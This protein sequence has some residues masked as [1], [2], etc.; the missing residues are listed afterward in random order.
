[1]YASDTTEIRRCRALLGGCPGPAGPP[2]VMGPQGNPSPRGNVAIV[3]AV[4]GNDSTASIGGSPYLT[5]SAAVAAVSSGQTVWILPGTY[6]LTTTLTIPSGIAIRGLNLQTCIL[7]MTAS[8]TATMITMGESSR[9]EDLTISLIG[10]LT[11]TGQTLIGIYFGGTSSSTSKLRTSVITVNNSSMSSSLSATVYAIQAAGT[12]TLTPTIFSFN[13]IKGSTINAISNGGGITRGIYLSGTNQMSTRDTNIYV[14]QPK[15]VSSTG[16]YVGV[17]AAESTGVG[18]IQ[19]RTTTIGT[20]LPTTGQSYTASDILQTYPATLTNPTYLASGGIQIGAGTDLITKTAGGQPF[21]TYIY[22]TIIYY[23]LKGTLTSATSGAWLWPGTQAISGGVFPD[24]GTPPAYYRIQQPCLLAGIS[25][26][27][28]T[29][30]SGTYTVNLLVQIIPITSNAIFSGYS[31]G[32]T[33][34]VTSVTSGTIQVGQ[35]LVGIGLNTTTYIMSGSGSTW[36]TNIFQNVANSGAPIV[37]NANGPLINTNFSL[38][39]TGTQISQINYN[40]SYA[41]NVGDRIHLYLTY[42]GAVNAN[43]AHDLT[44]EIALF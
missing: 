43:I 9:V 40:Y 1:M 41:L 23:G 31:T 5:V 2:G 42:T 6:V 36:T 35:Y 19:L 29:P 3:D 33:L 20:V 11:T 24:P 37:I 16:S 44:A 22:P 15:T 26:G 21:S 38:S 10:N 34:T 25:A 17:E 7:Q 28:N 12:G 32:Y 4:Y 30:P 27:L 8:T 18:C 14:A 39:F 13:S